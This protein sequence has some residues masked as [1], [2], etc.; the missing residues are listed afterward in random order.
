MSAAVRVVPY[1]PAWVEQFEAERERLLEAIGPYVITVEHGGSTAVPGLAAK[2][3]ID[4]LV[5]LR[6]LA[7]TPALLAPMAAL[8]YEYRPDYEVQ[9]PERRYFKKPARSDLHTHHVHMAEM[10]SQFWKD[11]LLFRDT[12]R[13]H[14]EIARA[15]AELKLELAVRFA[16][17]RDQYT[18]SKTGFVEEVLR[19]AREEGISG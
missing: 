10:T 12:L 9:L 1:D 6:S 5:G 13:S 11:H 3:V 7:D 16:N 18:D 19:Q 2:P 15:Y 4:I 14:P 17:D 8:D